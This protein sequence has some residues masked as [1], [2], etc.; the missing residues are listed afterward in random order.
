MNL[1]TDRTLQDVQRWKFLRDKGW[2]MSVEEQEEW[3]SAMKGSYGATDM[4]RVEAV[5]K[6]LSERLHDLGYL[7]GFLI[8]KQD[9]TNQDIP[10]KTDMDRYF[11]NVTAMRESITLP[12]GTPNAPSTGQRFD[13][14]MANNLE[15]ILIEIDRVTN[16]LQK[17]W[18]YA[19]DIF[20]GEV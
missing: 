4:N 7:H 20:T 10:T 17:S 1:I 12:V 3:L 13:Y 9:W 2:N 15:K 8:T 5:V 6:L 16:D 14:E 11:G 18:L 19:G